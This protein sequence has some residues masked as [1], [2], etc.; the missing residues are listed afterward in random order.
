MAPKGLVT[1]GRTR[2]PGSASRLDWNGNP[3]TFVVHAG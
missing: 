1:N 2:R 3:V